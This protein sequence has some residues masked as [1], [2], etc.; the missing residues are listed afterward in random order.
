MT[1]QVAIREYKT[2][3][4]EAVL[5]L[6]RLNTPTYFSPVEEKD[7]ANYLDHERED[8]FVLEIDHRI[9]G[10]GGINYFENK[11]EGRISWDF[12]DPQYQSQGFGSLLLN[13]RI[14]RLKEQKTIKKI[15]VRTSQLAYK[16][17]EKSGF[18]LTGITKDYWAKGYD[19]Y[20]MEYKK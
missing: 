4:K 12:L 7:L 2:Q 20:F 1:E 15:I 11:A 13:Y 16:F 9:I 18:I 3:D 5:N 14:S 6:L 19:L 10:C 17:Y 8:Y